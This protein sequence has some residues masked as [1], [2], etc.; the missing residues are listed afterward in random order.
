MQQLPEDPFEHFGSLTPDMKNISCI[1]TSLSESR[2]SKYKKFLFDG[3]ASKS[4]IYGLDD[5]PTDDPPA[6]E[7]SNNTLHL[8]ESIVSI[9]FYLYDNP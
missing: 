9:I 4:F 7:S 1:V 6:V 3:C 8:N 2:D 5:V